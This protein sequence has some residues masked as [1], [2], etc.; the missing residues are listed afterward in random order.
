MPVKTLYSHLFFHL[1]RFSFTQSATPPSIRI[2]SSY[3]SATHTSC[4]EFLGVD[5][6][7]WREWYFV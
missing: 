1:A 6:S 5:L 3:N 7:C 2:Y 4:D